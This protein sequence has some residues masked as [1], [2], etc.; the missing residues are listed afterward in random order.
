[1]QIQMTLRELYL[2]GRRL[3]EL[4][5]TALRATGRDGQLSAAELII[6]DHLDHHGDST[7]N[8]LSS[9]TGY[10][11][12]RVSVVVAALRSRGLVRTSISDTDRRRTHVQLTEPSRT[13]GLALVEDAAELGS[14]HRVEVIAALDDIYRALIGD[15]ATY[16][17]GGA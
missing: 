6:V 17:R 15:A 9:S 16:P 12:S 3:Q 5:T 14:G 11:Q 4:A 2:L 7:I 8:E 13:A 1:M 10:A